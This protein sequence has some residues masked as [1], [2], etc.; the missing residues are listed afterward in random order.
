MK[1]GDLS[2]L[3][4]MALGKIYDVQIGVQKRRLTTIL[5]GLAFLTSCDCYQ[6]VAGTV[7][8]KASGRPLKGVT[9]YN[10]SKEWCKTT[11]DTTG[12]FELSNVSGGI[13]CPP[14]TIIVEN[15][16]YKK[17][18][19]S[20]PA[21]GQEIVKL[22]REIKLPF[23]DS[24]CIPRPDILDNQ[25]VYLMA[26]KNAEFPGGKTAFFS[27]LQNN[28]RYPEEQAEWQGSIYVTFI[29]D[30][31]GNIRNECIYKRYFEGEI[32]P[33]E[34]VA[35]NLIKEMPT[36]S[37]AEKEGKKVYMRITLPVKF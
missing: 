32:S 7:I 28:L 13:R 23:I 29:V 2:K 1:M 18:E 36:W 12:H 14:M 17:Y 3:H 30:S 4:K 31:L 35:L 34:K 37:P 20:I 22:E 9:V 33:I 11:T 15:T 6:Q 10:K 27:Y 5:I 24:T 16:N 19:T 21:G 25:Q 8:D 26:D